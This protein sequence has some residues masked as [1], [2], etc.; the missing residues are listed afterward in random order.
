MNTLDFKQQAVL[1]LRPEGGFELFG[2]GE[3]KF[4]AKGL[5]EPSEAEIKTVTDR[6]QA[7]YDAQAYA[8]SRKKE[9]PTVEE[10]IHAIL[11]ND[12]ETLQVKR[13]AVKAKYPKP[14]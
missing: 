11:D 2:T 4:I 5:N 6:L 1:E 12:L 14:G 9:Y 13:Q 3:V 7:E 10:C 8:R